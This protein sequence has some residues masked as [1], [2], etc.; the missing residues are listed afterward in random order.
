MDRIDPLDAR[1]LDDFQ[2]DLPLDPRPFRRMAAQLGLCEASVLDRLSRMQAQG[3]IARVGATV[4]PNT[5]G[6][7]TLAAMAVPEDR[8]EAVAAIVGAEPGVNHSYL[9]EAEWNL[10]FVATA[11]DGAELAAA[12]DRISRKSGLRVMD[13]RLRRAFN[14]DLGFR[15]SGP[16]ALMTGGREAVPQILTDADRPLLQALTEGLPLIE[17]PFAALATRLGRSE[18]QVLQRIA[19]LLGAG[20][21]TRLGVIVRHRAL[22]WTSNAMV[23]WD[24]PAKAVGQAGCRLAAHPGVT[25]CY[26]RSPVPG[27][28]PY[29]LYCMIHARSRAQALQVL[30]GARRLPE[31]AGVPHRV[32][33]S[34]RCFKQSGARIAEVA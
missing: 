28:W 11:A 33:F 22:G 30:D 21:I 5:I 16:P 34:T 12:L 27:A 23:V 7:S 15:L 9:R 31:L 24:I 25:L 4:R 32:L 29:R 17:A 1:L 19:L 26:E 18:A 6:A 3:R 13:L 10:W 8:V 14:I 20:I 2:R